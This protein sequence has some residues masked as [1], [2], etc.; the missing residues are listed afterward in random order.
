MSIKHMLHAIRVGIRSRLFVC[1]LVVVTG[2][3]FTLSHDANIRLA[4]IIGVLVT[5]ETMIM[6]WGT[7]FIQMLLRPFAKKGSISWQ[8]LPVFAK[9]RV[10]VETQGLELNKN[11]AF[12]VRKDFDN[13]YINP[14]TRRIVIGD[15]VL[16]RLD[17]GPLT[18]LLG[19]EITHIKHRH[20]IKMLLWTMIIP[21]LATLPLLIVG[22]PSIVYDLVAYAMFFMVFL[23]ISWHNEYDADAGAARIA[24]TKNTISLL[25][26]WYQKDNGNKN[27]RLIHLF[28]AAF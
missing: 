23:F 14:L 13:A 15:R 10:L 28:I 3:L 17:D 2:Y 8:E 16:K 20:H 5:S 27:Q 19:H 26:K 11:R 22:T 12:G 18:A 24:G 21:A 4:A 25:K 1:I 7:S 6:L 9:F